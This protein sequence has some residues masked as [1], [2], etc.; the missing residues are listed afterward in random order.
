MVIVSGL[1]KYKAC[2][3]EVWTYHYTVLLIVYTPCYQFGTSNC[4]HKSWNKLSQTTVDCRQGESSTKGMHY[5][6]VQISNP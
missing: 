1:A 2:T 5:L 4:K 3:M 6:D